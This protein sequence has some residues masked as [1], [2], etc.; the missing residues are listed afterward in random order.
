MN[1]NQLPDKTKRN[2]CGLNHRCTAGLMRKFDLFQARL[3][4][5][6][7]SVRVQPRF[8]KVVAQGLKFGW[9]RRAVCYY[10]RSCVPIFRAMILQDRQPN[11][12][13]HL[14]ARWQ[15]TTSTR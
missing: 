13:S 3:L 9:G 2:N 5:L 11:Q 8:G 1:K 6:L 15:A 7:R 12:I 10:G 4:R 14:L